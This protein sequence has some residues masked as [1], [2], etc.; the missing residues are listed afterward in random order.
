MYERASTAR[1]STKNTT[2]TKTKIEEKDR[3]K[4]PALS[5]I[6]MSRL[7][8]TPCDGQNKIEPQSFSQPCT[9]P[10]PLATTSTPI[11]SA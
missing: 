9:L 7:I 8:G 10:V 6:I 2:K 3:K 4:I 1:H 5:D 11:W